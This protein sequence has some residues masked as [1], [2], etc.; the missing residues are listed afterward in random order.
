MYCR[1][2]Y[3]ILL[4]ELRFAGVNEGFDSEASLGITKGDKHTIYWHLDPTT[5]NTPFNTNND[6]QI[7]FTVKPSLMGIVQSINPG[8]SLIPD[9]VHYGAIIGVQ[10]GTKRM[11]EILN[12]VYSI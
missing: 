12:Q 7:V 1:L 3:Q 10:G 6:Y 8:Q 4:S 2:F 9:W 11:L 5:E